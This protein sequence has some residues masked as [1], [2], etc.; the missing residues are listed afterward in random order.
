MENIKFI[1]E[2]SSRI[3][4]LIDNLY[5]KMP[6]IEAA[7]GRLVT[8]SYKMTEELPIIKRRSHAFAHILKNIP[9]VCILLYII[10]KCHP[11]RIEGSQLRFFAW[12]RMTLS[13]TNIQLCKNSLD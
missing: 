13:I 1:I 6:E 11:K 9:I 8:E 2:K 12:L 7:R 4:G 3:Q 10:Q 5:E